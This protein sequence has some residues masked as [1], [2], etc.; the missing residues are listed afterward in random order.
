GNPG[1]G[2]DCDTGGRGVCARGMTVCTRGELACDALASPGAEICNGLDDDCDGVVDDGNPGG[3]AACDTGRPGV[4]ANG[5]TLCRDAALTCRPD[6]PASAEICNGLDDDCDQMVDED[7]P[8]GGQACDTGDSGA[9]ARGRTTCRD[10]APACDPLVEPA[11]ERCNGE[12]DDCDGIADEDDLDSGSACQTG[13]PGACAEGITLCLAGRP[14]C[15]PVNPPVAE[16]CDA[17]D[18][19]CDGRVD[20]GTEGGD[21]CQTELP[22]VCAAGVTVCMGA[23]LLC[24]P[25]LAPSAEVCDGLDNDCDGNVDEQ[26]ERVG[27]TCGTGRP[28]ICARGTWLCVDGALACDP[29]QDPAPEVCN[30]I[31]DSCDGHIDEGTRNR[32]GQCGPN[33]FEICDGLDQDCDGTVDEM[34]PC[35]EGICRY[36]RCVLPCQNN[37]CIDRGVQCINGVC[38]DPC[39]LLNCPDDQFCDGQ[40]CV[41]PCVGVECDGSERCIGGQ[42]EADDCVEF[43]CPGGERCVNADCEPDP[44]AAARCD[45]GSFCRD[46]DCVPSCAAVSCPLGQRCLDGQCVTDDCADIGCPDGQVCRGGECQADACAGVDCPRGQVCRDGLCAGDPCAHVNCPPGEECVVVEGSAQC[47]FGSSMPREDG[48]MIEVDAGVGADADVEADADLDAA[49]SAPDADIGIIDLFEG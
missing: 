18:N 10:A 31:D 49:V 8:G 30:G 28:G 29:E 37:E 33:A 48:G 46:G 16:I 13:R 25:E 32:C 22:G 15:D 21:P 11:E 20:E 7:N 27:A 39:E 34:A 40:R 43:G 45:E 44:C 23:E 2:D 19:D 42:C 17:V 9:C 6:V 24:Q 3:G 12:D 35:K 5:T 26:A 4:C 38:V 47:V 1:G 36:G 41:D 14:T